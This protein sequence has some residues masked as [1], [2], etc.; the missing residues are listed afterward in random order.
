[1][2]PTDST[3]Y[4]LVHLQ[5]AAVV[6]FF[7]FAPMPNGQIG[8]PLRDANPPAG[9]EASQVEQ[10]TLM[11]RGAGIYCVLVGTPYSVNTYELRSTV[12]RLAAFL[13]V[14]GIWTGSPSS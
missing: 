7:P 8:R 4:V 5:L 2:A 11:R 14:P 1:M 3:V 12:L 10:K 9:E 6:L 13:T